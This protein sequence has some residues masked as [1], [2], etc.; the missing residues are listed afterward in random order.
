[1]QSQAIRGARIFSGS[2][3]LDQHA[4]V[5]TEGRIERI[6][7]DDRVESGT[8]CLD[9]PGGT[10][11][12][13]FIDLQVNGGGGVLFN[14]APTFT[15][16][17]TMLKAHRHGGT[18]A[19][20]PTIITDAQTVREQ[21]LESIQEAMDRGL[22]GV[23]GLHFEG[24]FL[25]TGRRGVHSET[26]VRPIDDDD[27]TWL[28]SISLCRVMLTLAPEHVSPERIEKLSHA[29]VIVCAGHSA[30]TLEQT[31]A[32][33]AAGL[34]GFTHLF[35]AMSPLGSREPG[36]VGAA[37]AS[38]D[39][40]CGIIVDGHHVHPT[41]VLLALRAL[42]QG[43]LYLVSDSM[44]TVGAEEKSF[45]LYGETIAEKD[46]HLVNQEGRLAGSAISMIDAVRNTHKDVGVPLDECLRMAS[47]YPAE[48]IG[49]ASQ[50]GRID[51]GY[52]ADLVHFDEDFEVLNTWVV[53]EQHSH[54]A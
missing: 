7:P 8:P 33:I 37:L 32:A 19:L 52:R 46:G 17:G 2:E 23:L 38:A 49:D 15:S 13:G 25:D 53:G 6:C 36:M 24:P 34:R 27:V 14:N 26:H 51:A 42:P 11:A 1:M 22:D 3:F 16:L 12:P 39:C 35:N 5:V 54:H 31:N 43:K 45:E 10:V 9:L 40:W 44:A 20:L 18:T 30:A 50:R 29:G 28:E 41:N 47:L 4:I 21:A 48:L